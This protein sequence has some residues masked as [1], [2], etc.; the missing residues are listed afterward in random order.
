M[1]EGFKG[2]SNYPSSYCD[3]LLKTKFTY[4]E[5]FFSYL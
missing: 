5:L 3:S 4:V 1:G 2:L